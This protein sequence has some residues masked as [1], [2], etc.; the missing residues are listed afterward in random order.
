DEKVGQGG[1]GASFGHPAENRARK[2]EG[3]PKILPA[4]ARRTGAAEFERW[5]EAVIVHHDNSGAA[6]TDGEAN[7]VGPARDCRGNSPGCRTAWRA[8][9]VPDTCCCATAFPLW[10]Y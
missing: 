9:P 6:M 2:A 1:Y 5:R 3:R 8:P 4:H 10:D 7:R